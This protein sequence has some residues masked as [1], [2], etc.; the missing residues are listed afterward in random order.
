MK[1]NLPDLP[2]VFISSFKRKGLNQLKDMIWNQLT[3]F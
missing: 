2:C 1:K 3:I